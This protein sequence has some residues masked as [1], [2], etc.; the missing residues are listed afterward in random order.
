MDTKESVRHEVSRSRS[1]SKGDCTSNSPSEESV[2]FAYQIGETLGDYRI[3]G[4]LGDGT[5]G[6]VL[7]I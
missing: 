2:H 3:T 7:Q 4:H 6:R 5:F 1:R